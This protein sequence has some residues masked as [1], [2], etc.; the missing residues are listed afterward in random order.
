MRPLCFNFLQLKAMVSFMGVRFSL[1]KI[2]VP[3]WKL[4]FSLFNFK[5]FFLL[6]KIF[7]QFFLLTNSAMVFCVLEVH[8]S[9]PWHASISLGFTCT[10]MSDKTD[11]TVF[12][13][14]LLVT[15]SGIWLKATLLRLPCWAK[16][17]W[18]DSSMATLFSS[19]T[20][21]YFQPSIFM[22]Q[23][24]DYYVFQIDDLIFQT[25]NALNYGF[26]YFI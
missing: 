12:S 1:T 4:C 3:A 26:F 24:F 7:S 6:A 10:S 21:F 5:S 18:F 16:S 19:F 9:I 14:L 20:Q 8:L 13:K 22:L 11:M 17:L 25:V 15:F 2:L 23:I